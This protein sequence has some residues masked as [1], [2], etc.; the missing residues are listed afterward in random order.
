M[1]TRWYRD[2]YAIGSVQGARAVALRVMFAVGVPLIGGALLGHPAAGVAGGVTAL[3]V[4]M[5]D[6]GT[7]RN[8]RVGTML[9]GWLAICVGGTLGHELARV[10]HGNEFVILASALLAGWA[11]GSQPGIAAVMRFF[12]LAAAA[13]EGM[14]FAGRD[15]LWALAVGGASALVAAY[16]MWK[17]SG[18]PA[19]DNVIDWRAGVRRAFA[20]SGAGPRF[21]ICY[22]IAAAVAL[23]A[24]SSL[25][26]MDPYWA[27]F[28]VLMVMRREGT[29][30]LKLTLHYAVGTLA[31]VIVAAVILR[32]VD[33]PLVLTVL[34]TLVAAFA[35]IGFAANPALGYMAFTMFLLFVVH[36]IMVSSGVVPH[37]L[38]ARI[39][40]VA[41]G[42]ALAIVGTMAATYP[43]FDTRSA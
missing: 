2:L 14:H 23:F 13:G 36:V 43:R 24:A 35:R 20:G 21:T 17:W 22:A 40:D 25:R 27:T 34:A 4:T 38:A 37:L 11:S 29:A 16:L 5:S 39:Y 19:A 9:A 28:V 33:D 8:V 10:P 41:V 30:S 32:W 1:D 26:V 18:L 31:G 42:C 7:T 15:V 6:I 3:F 12:A